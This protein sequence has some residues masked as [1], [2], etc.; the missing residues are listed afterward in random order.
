MKES[1]T[2]V[3]AFGG[4]PSF[5]PDKSPKDKPKLADT[6]VLEFGEQNTYHCTMYWVV[7][8]VTVNELY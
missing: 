3:T 7:C 2:H 4:S 5:D 1:R 8:S 6:T